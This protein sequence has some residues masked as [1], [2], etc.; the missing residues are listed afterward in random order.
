[1]WWIWQRIYHYSQ[2]IF[3]PPLMESWT[4]RL[5]SSGKMQIERDA[6][7]QLQISRDFHKICRTRERIKT[8]FTFESQNVIL[9]FFQ[10]N[11][12]LLKFKMRRL[13]APRHVIGTNDISI[14]SESRRLWFKC[15]NAIPLNQAQNISDVTKLIKRPMKYYKLL[16]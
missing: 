15:C 10:Q 16:T 14:M 13:P 6:A 3:Y 11:M 12:C 8:K 4:I 5:S 9:I 2:S 7:E 1:M